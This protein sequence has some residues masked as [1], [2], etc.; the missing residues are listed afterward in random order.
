MRFDMPLIDYIHYHLS[1]PILSLSLP[2]SSV[3]LFQLWPTVSSPKMEMDS[4][5]CI[6]LVL[7]FNIYMA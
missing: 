7:T 2:D 4:P 3:Q 1:R 6:R 5:F